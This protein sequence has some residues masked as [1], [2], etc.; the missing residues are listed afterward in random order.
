M[1]ETDMENDT[2][3]TSCRLASA[4][5][6]ALRI[7]TAANPGVTWAAKANNVVR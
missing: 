3:R 5:I 7:T 1:F 4:N 2:Y 6:P